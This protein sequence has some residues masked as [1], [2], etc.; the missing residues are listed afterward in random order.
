MNAETKGSLS[1]LHGTKQL[2]VTTK[3]PIESK[4][5]NAQ[6]VYVCNYV[7]LNIYSVSVFF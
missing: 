6:V 7:I 4:V 3:I 5:F 2:I 1:A